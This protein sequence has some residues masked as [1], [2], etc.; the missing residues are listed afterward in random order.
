MPYCI[1]YDL[2]I[3]VQLD[4]NILLLTLSVSVCIEAV[5]IS[6]K[7]HLLEASWMDGWMA[8]HIRELNLNNSMYSINVCIDPS[9]LVTYIQ[10]YILK[11]I[12]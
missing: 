3:I 11:H 7:Q 6:D 12:M 10:S 2:S 1:C 9:V 5:N 4:L 8:H